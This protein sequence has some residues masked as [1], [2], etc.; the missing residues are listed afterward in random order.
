MSDAINN[1]MK[2]DKP[3]A[4][5][6]SLETDATLDTLSMDLDFLSNDFEFRMIWL[7]TFC[8]TLIQTILNLYQSILL[9]SKIICTNLIKSIITWYKTLPQI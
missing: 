2:V 7:M 1:Q 9:S 4:L 3:A 6:K 8:L 5:G